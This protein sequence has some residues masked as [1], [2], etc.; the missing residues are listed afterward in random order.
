MQGA[1]QLFMSVPQLI[2]CLLARRGVFVDDTMCPILPR[3]ASKKYVNPSRPDRRDTTRNMN[4]FSSK[5][6][7]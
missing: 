3:K 4:C 6:V 2:V 5:A 1:N 7:H